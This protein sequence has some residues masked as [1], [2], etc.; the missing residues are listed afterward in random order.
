MTSEGAGPVI[1]VGNSAWKADGIA[2]ELHKLGYTTGATTDIGWALDESPS[3][4]VLMP[5]GWESTARAML[6]GFDT[7][8]NPPPAV[9]IVGNED[10]LP[11]VIGPS[12]RYFKE[13]VNC[14]E[15]SSAIAFALKRRAEFVRHWP[16]LLN[17][18][19]LEDI[20]GVEE[21]L[22]EHTGIT[23]RQDWRVTFQHALQERMVANLSPT[24]ADYEAILRGAGGAREVH[25]LACRV[26][27]GE[28]HFW[29]YS[30][31]MNA[32][33]SL[34]SSIYARRGRNSKIKV[35]SAGCSTGEEPYSIIMAVFEALGEYVD[36]EVV[37][38]DINPVSL[39]TARLGVY[40]ERS[41]RNLPSRLLARFFDSYDHHHIAKDSI[42]SRARFEHLNL[43]SDDV[44]EWIRENGPFDAVFCRNVTIYFTHEV[45]RKVVETLASSLSTGGGMFLGS[46]ETVHPPISGM[47]LMQETGAFYYRRSDPPKPAEPPPQA[48][49]L[50]EAEPPVEEANGASAQAAAI[51]HRG[52]DAIGREDVN[53]ASALFTDLLKAD[54]ESP[55]GNTGAALIMANQGREVESRELLSRVIAQGGEPAEAHFILAILDE[56]AH[57]PESALSNYAKAL[58]L[59]PDFFMAHINRA[60]ILKREGNGRLFVAEMR[61]ALSILRRTPRIPSWVTGGLGMEAILALVAEAAEESE[62]K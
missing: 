35:W 27:V 19:R 31:Q 38:T 62:T 12:M 58:K 4:L 51:F 36:L 53:T 45:A 21:V 37:G 52:L 6:G 60:W 22:G 44:E 13:P 42:K 32:I 54:P 7:R 40:S 5:E 41:L 26:A 11:Y 1:V 55:L 30:G 10:T 16:R 33:K 57:K 23:V 9:I 8:D 24:V 43:R 50:V 49:P 15:L 17:I 46:S 28:T 34:V 3:V 29:R 47:D 39:A 2:S 25:L 20:K 59:D 14:M 18:K 56:R 61:M 48:Q